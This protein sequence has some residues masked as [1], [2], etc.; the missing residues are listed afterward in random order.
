MTWCWSLSFIV[1][2]P[3]IEPSTLAVEAQSLNH[4][5]AREV[6]WRVVFDGHSLHTMNIC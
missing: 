5:T 4:W 3:G 1:P 6:S 2:W